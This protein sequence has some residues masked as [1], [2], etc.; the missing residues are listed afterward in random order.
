MNK[1]PEDAQIPCILR[2]R[3]KNV[4]LKKHFVLLLQ[5]FGSLDYTEE[6]LSKL[7][8]EIRT[9]IAALGGNPYLE[10]LVEELVNKVFKKVA[11]C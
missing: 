1:H 6:K 7:A 2:Q 11:D 10:A 4:D 5:K 3:T 9:E 8:G